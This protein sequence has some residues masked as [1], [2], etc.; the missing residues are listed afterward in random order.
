MV[1]LYSKRNNLRSEHVKT[2][3]MSR[4]MFEFL[5]RICNKYITNLAGKF[6]Q[7]CP[8]DKSVI[9]GV[10]KEMF[11]LSLKFQVPGLKS[12]Y[13]YNIEAPA[14]GE[15]FNQFNVLDYIEYLA[16]Y[17]Q[18]VEDLDYHAYFQHQHLKVK[19]TSE[20]FKEFHEEI[21]DAFQE[22]GLLYTL[23][24]NKKVER[25]TS[26]DEL[27]ESAIV[28]INNVKEDGLKELLLDAISFYRS[29]R[30]G[31]NHIAVEKIWDALER[32]KTVCDG[33]NKKI[34]TEKLIDLISLGDGN[35][36]DLFNTEFKTLT[37]I[38]NKYRIRHHETDKIEIIDNN[39]YDYL[40]SR[41]FALVVLAIKYV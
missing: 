18:D 8:D 17:M 2:D 27:I 16:E 28:N 29:P 34:S 20:I 30:P 31:D 33:V 10:D 7:Y 4:D 25:I 35:Y 19:K 21:N 23:S 32:V 9:C 3:S 15:E 6:P 13:N 12:D 37:D 1:E 39:Y 41:C 14:V 26:S 24:S 38:G 11:C 36:K 5:I 22:M 40:F